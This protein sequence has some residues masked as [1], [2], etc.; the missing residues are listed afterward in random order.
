M[1]WMI[2]FVTS[3]LLTICAFYNTQAQTTIHGYI[4]DGELPVSFANVGIEDTNQG[5]YSDEEGNFILLIEDPRETVLVITSIGFFKSKIKLDTMS[6][7][8]SNIKI[9]MKASDLL[10]N[11]IVVTGNM[12]QT[13]LKE[14][15]VK[16]EV[17]SSEFLSKSPTNNIVEALHTVN[18]IQEQVACGVCGTNEIR[19]NGME[20]PYTLVLIDGMPIMSSLSSI[21]GFN[22]IPTSI[23]E[24]IEI[25]KGPSSTLY[26][27]EA[28]GGVI[29]IITKHPDESPILA[30]NSFVS[31]TREYNLDAALTLKPTNKTFTTIGLNYYTNQYRF[32]YNMDGFTDI[33]LNN[34][35]SIYNKWQIQNKHVN[36][37]SFAL[38]YYS[39][40]RFGGQMNWQYDDKGSNLIYGEAIRTNR[41]EFIG[42]SPFALLYENFKFD[43]SFTLH[44]QESYYGT[45]NYSADQSVLFFNLI[46][47][48]KLIKHSLLS[49]ISLRNNQYIDNTPAASN[50][51]IWIPGLFLQDEWK[52]NNSTSVLSGI[53]F[54]HHS[55][56]GTIFSPRINIKHN[57]GDYTALR[58]NL[59]TGFRTVNLFTEDHAALSGSRTVVIQTKLNP[60]QSFNANLNFN[61]IFILGEST[62]TFDID[63]F[64]TYFTNKIIPDY[65]SNNQYI[66]YNNLS[67]YAI[68]RG[69]SF[70]IQQSF[71]FPL[72]INVGGTYQDV[73]Q[74]NENTFTNT[75]E[76]TPQL[77]APRF[78]ATFALSYT[79]KPWDFSIDYTGRIMGPQ[80]L[81]EYA[82]PYSR[83]EISP[84]YTLQNVQLNKQ[85]G[86]KFEAYISVKN[87]LNW[88]QDSPLIAPEDP[89]GSDFDTAYV[90]G[91]LQPR[92]FIAGIK[93]T[94]NK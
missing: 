31:S 80:H 61:H 36:P 50:E 35:I 41:F 34:R 30:I 43:Y 70:G 32:D 17:L 22:G 3:C 53:R 91:S 55:T 63:A 19:I 58:L 64:Y 29:N 51:N 54:D 62:G 68:S 72:N 24:Q 14:S 26:G 92:R 77:F 75:K 94:I 65:D 66:F 82:F 89:F 45:T 93:F 48:K 47:T 69:I 67:G 42:T 85:L 90:W 40:D 9:M 76:K 18:G 86:E 78:S 56:H 71:L 60:E 81:P 74:V 33:P 37:T 25:V 87:I 6:G 28:V 12:Q 8:P 20:G 83:E 49:G 27:T 73:Y 10:L 57:L 11:Q 38:R 46:W 84:W 7:Y 13:Y 5:T 79:I 39:E 44:K 16:M 23:I 4:S 1:K 88:T 59:G 15:P 21:Y 52:L 2:L